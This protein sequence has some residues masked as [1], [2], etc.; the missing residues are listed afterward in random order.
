MLV[1]KRRLSSFVSLVMVMSLS[2]CT[3][4]KNIVPN[5]PTD[6]GLDASTDG[7]EPSDTSV[8]TGVVDAGVEDAGP[9]DVGVED[10]GPEDAGPVD[11]GVEDTGPEDAEPVDAG[12][13][14]AGPEDVGV[15]DAGPDDPCDPDPCKDGETCVADDDG[16]VLCEPPVPCGGPCPDDLACVDDE[17]VPHSARPIHPLSTSMSTTQ[18]PYFE[19]E[20][21]EGADGTRIEICA[22]HSCSAVLLTLDLEGDEGNP[23]EPLS[24]GVYFWRATAML[25]AQPLGEPS[26][27]WQVRVGHSTAAVNTSWGSMFDYNLDGFADGIVGGCGISACTPKVFIHQGGLDGF[28][29]TP[30]EVV[31]SDSPF[32]GFAVANAGDVN[33]DGYPDLIVGAGM[34]DSAHVYLVGPDGVSAEPSQTWNMPGAFYG[35]SV[36]GAGDVNGDGYGDVVVGTMLANTAFLYYGGPDGPGPVPDVPLTCPE[37]GVCAVSVAGGGDFNGD[38]F[39]DVIIGSPGALSDKA[40]L[41][42][43]GPEGIPPEPAG[44]LSGSGAYGTSV[45]IAGDV[46]G[47]GY[48]DV[49][50]GAP[51]SSHAF[52]YLGSADGIAKINEISM[53]GGASYGISVSS[54]GDVNADGLSDVVIGGKFLAEV[55]LGDNATGIVNAPISLP[56]ATAAFADSVAGVGDADGNGYDDV[57]IGAT[58]Q[59][60]SYLYLG[61][62]GDFPTFPSVELNAGEAA[63][64]YGFA[65]AKLELKYPWFNEEIAPYRSWR[66]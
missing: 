51:D 12:V 43:G 48:I 52:V 28:S 32:F 4:S 42:H 65:V 19:V 41:F 7:V 46:N 56:G 50:V 25:G 64:G 36:S 15:E 13:E 1:K 40:F 61:A 33:G 54:A 35:F 23:D 62:E 29:E 37:L 34:V 2:A 3:S 27:T 24:P 20:L 47:D 49:V 5:T 63:P 57:F 30:T 39:S 66:L 38:R 14:D 58:D 11:A 17:C 26:V 53:V 18:R 22:D 21:T 59:E 8:D 44:V 9:E 16:G 45:D 6:A 10:A 60:K 31:T 55:W